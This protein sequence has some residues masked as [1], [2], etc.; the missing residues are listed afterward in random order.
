[1]MF[2]MVRIVIISHS[3]A[4]TDFTMMFVQPSA[5]VFMSDFV[6]ACA[7]GQL[8]RC[9]YPVPFIVLVVQL[10]LWSTATEPIVGL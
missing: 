8:C 2:S 3:A 1:M 7:I 10:V 6:V 5:N 9:V 4:I